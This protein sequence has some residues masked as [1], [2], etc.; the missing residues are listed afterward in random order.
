YNGTIYISSGDGF[1]YAFAPRGG[2]GTKPSETI[3]SPANGSQ[4]ANPDGSF[5]ITGSSTDGS[6]VKAVEVAIQSGGATGP[7]Y[8]AATN[9]WGLA[10]FRNTA[11]LASPGASSTAWTYSVPLPASGGAYEVFA[12][13]VN[14]ANIVDKGS[15]AYFTVSPSMNEPTVHV[16]TTDT[17]PGSTFSGTGNAFKPGETVTFTLLG[18][19]VATATVGTKGNVPKTAIQMPSTATF[20]STALTLTGNT[21]GKSASAIVFVT[22]EWTQYGYSALRT[23]QEPNDEVI[24]HTIFAGASILNPYWIY[25]SGAAINTSPAVVNGIAYFGNDSGTLSAVR[26]ATGSPVWTYRIPS[27]API[28]SSP[29]V[30]S[31]GQII[32]GANDGNL[33]VLNSSGQAATTV[34]LG[35]SLGA[36]AYANGTIVVASNSG[37]VYSLSDP[38]WTTNWSANAGS[39]VTSAAAYDAKAGVVIVGT[40]NGNVIAYNSGTGAVRW[41]AATGG[42]INGLA[43][44]AAASHVYVGSSDGYVYAYTENT[45]S[46]L[47]KLAGDGHPVTAVDTN[48]N[49]PAFGTAGGT[50]YDVTASGSVYF[51]RSYGPGSIAG[52]AGAGTDEFGSVTNG[53]LELLRT[54]DGGWHFATGST[55][56]PGVSPVI[57]DAMIYAGLQNGD[58]YAF[59]PLGYTPPPQ[60]T[61]QLGSVVVRVNGSCSP[62]Q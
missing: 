27:G 11:T 56:G 54:N 9:T 6:S 60:T 5:T 52:L 59:T 15:V 22:N 13:T 40:S 14:G 55:F 18:N 8:N 28:R 45:G 42:T 35:G 37:A 29:A 16:S 7:W 31:T 61:V 46:L 39:A 4:V 44:S 30:D 38:G 34:A 49:G 53:N 32:F 26:T 36:P 12:N 21:S 50:L 24:A 58:F 19:T 1:L 62:V 33:Y 48:G 2:N 3:A 57:L 25:S 43:I 47:W 23:A 10:P 20:G 41:T 51:Q 17:P